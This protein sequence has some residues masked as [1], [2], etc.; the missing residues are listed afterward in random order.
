[1]MVV[2]WGGWKSPASGV[3]EAMPLSVKAFRV[4]KAWASG[5]AWQEVASEREN[6]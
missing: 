4:T 6:A 1:M 3:V 5:E 2:D